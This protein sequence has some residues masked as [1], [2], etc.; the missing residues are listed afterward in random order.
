[1]KSIPITLLGLII[2]IFISYLQRL[3]KPN[4]SKI[5]VLFGYFI[6]LLWISGCDSSGIQPEGVNESSNKQ[7]LKTE[8]VVIIVIDGPRFSETWG[9][10]TKSLIPYM[11][12]ELARQGIHYNWFYN[13]GPSFTSAG[14]TALTTGHYQLMQ[15]DGSEFPQRASIFQYWLSATQSPPTKSCIITSK[16]KLYILADCSNLAWRGR[17]NPFFDTANREDKETFDTAIRYFDQYKPK[18]SLIHFRGPDHNGHANDWEGYLNSI[19]ETDQYVYEFWQY[20]QNHSYYKGKTTLFVTND[21]GR[22]LDNV[23]NGFIS[24]GDFCEGCLH[25]NLFAIG[26]DFQAGITINEH[27]ELIDLAPTIARLLQINS[28]EFRGEILHELFK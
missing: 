5:P 6:I 11:A 13:N 16:E 14:H 26:P 3:P 23:R 10:P 22:H 25:I 21:H 27:R 20:L 2:G 19:I 4:F 8:N 17:F 24:H 15:N 1:M 28:F 7:N 12:G 9:D 18:L